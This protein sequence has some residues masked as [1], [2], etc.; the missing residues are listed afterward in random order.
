MANE[1][2]RETRRV[3]GALAA[4]LG[5]LGLHEVEDPRAAAQVRRPL[6]RVLGT[7]LLGLLAGSRSLRDLE[8][9]T[10]RL[11]LPTRRRLNL[12]GKLPDTTVRNLLMKLRPDEISA[13]LH[14]Q[15]RSAHR[16]KQLQPEGL[17]F[18]V[19]AIDG[20]YSVTRLPEGAYAQEQDGRWILRTMTCALVSARAPVVLDA[21][22]VPA[23]TNEMGIFQAVLDRLDAAYDRLDLF[24]L[25]TV[26]AGMTSEANA[27]AVRQHGWHYLMALKDTQ[28]TLIDE[29]ERLLG[30]QRRTPPTAQTTTVVNNGKLEIRR[31]WFTGE[32]AEYHG[33][34][35]LQTMVR[36]QREV[37]EDGGKVSR[38]DRYFVS[39]LAPKDL[40][41][42][43]WLGI[44]RGHWRVENEVHGTLDRDYDEDDSPWLYATHGQLMVKLLRRVGLNLMHLHRNVSRRGE[45]QRGIPWKD[46]TMTAMAVLIGGT[47]SNLAG[48]RWPSFAHPLARGRPG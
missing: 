3:A 11:S 42:E 6:A 17:P 20:K 36:V 34:S 27:A 33:W 8:R 30:P 41:A 14:R 47:E 2:A 38:E 22:P 45:T 23:G 29:A 9:L 15:V 24:Q 46:L 44:V 19:C 48:L 43:Q 18:G 39:S 31:V 13:V 37:V 40:T 16:S 4:G 28:P 1:Q 10:G 5:R 7:L 25:V 12:W 21:V 35:H 26:D 32:A